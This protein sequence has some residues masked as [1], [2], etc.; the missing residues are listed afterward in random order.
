M[1]TT[2]IDVFFLCDGI[3]IPY[4]YFAHPLDAN[5]NQGKAQDRRVYTK[6]RGVHNIQYLA[7]KHAYHIYC[8]CWCCCLLVL[9]VAVNEGKQP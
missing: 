9:P 5:C 6:M 4:V 2:T 8:M 1:F 7:F 3:G